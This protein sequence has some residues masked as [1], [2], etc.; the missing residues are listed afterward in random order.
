M[1]ARSGPFS[2]DVPDSTPVAGAG[3]R[4]LY[5]GEGSVYRVFNSSDRA[6]A[7]D[8]RMA[9]TN[10]RQAGS[11]VQ[12]P[13]LLYPTM[14]IDVAVGPSDQVSGFP[15]GLRVENGVIPAQNVQIRGSYDLVRNADGTIAEGERRTGRFNFPSRI[16]NN[17][18]PVLLVDLTYSTQSAVYRVYNTGEHTFEIF[19]AETKAATAMQKAL[20]VDLERRQSM[21]VEIPV[22]GSTL[23]RI[24]VARKAN[25]ES[26]SG[27]FELVG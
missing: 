25:G 12:L 21:D 2:F 9:V 6:D 8:T 5:G 10:E 23:K 15:V 22:T 26:I 3:R 7:R 13:Q 1:A 16:P 11:Y 14:S 24:F 4:L 20:S 18:L 19:V 17:F 27:V